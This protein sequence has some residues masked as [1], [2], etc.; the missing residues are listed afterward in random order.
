MKTY[1]SYVLVCGGSGCL[2]SGSEEIKDAFISEIRKKELNE[3]VKVIETGCVGA[4][5]LGPI[6]IV[7]PGGIFYKKLT[8]SDVP[9]IVEEHLLKGR[10]VEKLVYKPL[11]ADRKITSFQEMD[12]FRFQHKNVLKNCGVIDP[13]SIEEYIGADGYQALARVL[14]S[15]SPEDGIEEIKKSGLRGRGGGGF[16]AGVKWEFARRAKS[17]QKYIIC[18]ADEGDPGAFMDRSLLEGDPHSVM[19]GMAIGAYAIGADQG[20]VYVRAEYPLAVERLEIAI[21]QAREFGLLG[22]NILDS[23]F[24]FDVEIRVGAG[25]F[26]CGE[27][28]ALIASIEGKRGEPRPRP[29]FPAQ[30]GLWGRP[31]IINNV[32]TLANVPL[33]ILKGSS[34]F[35]KLGTEKS[36]G[37]KIFALAGD[38]KNT[39]LVEVL[40]GIPLGKIIYDIGGGIPK[41]RKFKAVQCGGPSGGCI[42]KEYLNVPVDYESLQELGAIMGSGG[43]IVMDENTCMVDIAR[44]FLDFIQEESCGKCPPCRIGTKRMLEIL[45]RI[46][47]G[48]GEEDDIERLIKLGEN[49]KRT[50]LCGLGQTAS[51]P[52]LSTIRHFREEYEQHIKHKRCP[53]AVCQALF[54][55]PCQHACPAEVDVPGY[56]YLISQG[57][58][59]EAVALI[60]ERNPLVAVSGRVCHNPCET[61]CRRQDIEEALAIRDLKRFAADYLLN[62]GGYPLP[63]LQEK[64]GKSVA[65]VGSG[66]AGL[67]CAYHLARMG[68]EATVF[69]A[70]S[71]VGGMLAVGIPQYR[72]PREILE[73]EVEAIKKVGVEIKTN[74]RVGKDVSL[75]EFFDQGYQAV[76]IAAGAHKDMKLGME[77]ERL[78]NVMGAADFLR[79]VNLG[80][81]EKVTGIVAVIGGGNAAINAAR[82]ALR[83]GADE[84]NIIYRRRR[85]DMPAHPEGICQA[86]IEGIR[87]HFL[88]S[89]VRLQ[90]NGRVCKMEC[91]HMR[92]GDF[93]LSGRRRP[94]PI[95][96]SKFTLNV[97]FVIKAIGQ[98]PD[99]SFITNH[100]KMKVSK[101]ETLVVNPDDLH[102]SENGIFAGG[103]LVRGPSTVIEVIRDG[104]N[105]AISIDKYL[106]GKG[107][108]E[109]KIRKEEKLDET[110]PSSENPE[111]RLR[112]KKTQN[113]VKNNVKSFVEVEPAYSEDEARQEA[114]RCLRCDI[115]VD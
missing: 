53:A 69:E 60:R 6:A 38:I 62:N 3:E 17:N 27:E 41:E 78:E 108:I 36:K 68:Y 31:T 92:L 26:V 96:G 48:E 22:E 24:S 90:G 103:D 89:P 64:K 112:V 11:S 67:T 57:K 28:T 50:A 29:P 32:E 91:L 25:A 54:R 39:G 82:S 52:V 99:T 84:V 111:V 19:E 37:T 93:D 94:V 59:E 75:N 109:E 2:S 5:D 49:I 114:S 97:D 56:I 100:F 73:K 35:A 33:I 18:N 104:I 110:I 115:Q 105:A 42:P 4:C 44:F 45:T 34:W 13:T 58:H 21:K 66:P 72:L 63:S 46:T 102:A 12:F 51:N 85:E 9:L 80:E 113:K 83:L 86:E 61:K 76:F 79:G 107:V 47:E 15:M 77:G 95:E 71:V 98:R 106:G 40:M 23:K 10:V 101:K 81:I 7:H 70:L 87:M 14:T 16:P 88:T 30:S 1:R 43:L 55:S 65:V 74:I 8:P 20:Y